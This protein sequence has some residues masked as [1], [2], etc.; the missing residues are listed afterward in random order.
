MNDFTLYLNNANPIGC[1][2]A[3]IVPKLQ[4]ALAGYDS[5]VCHAL[6]FGTRKLKATKRVTIRIIDTKNMIHTLTK[7]HIAKL[8]ADL[9]AIDDGT[10]ELTIGDRL[11]GVVVTE[12]SYYSREVIGNASDDEMFIPIPEKFMRG[13]DESR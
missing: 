2:K 10:T 7:K 3:E 4:T 11:I 13:L 1:N 12:S 8:R 9:E 6:S 5:G